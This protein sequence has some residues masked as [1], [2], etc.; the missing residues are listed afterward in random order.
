MEEKLPFIKEMICEFEKKNLIPSSVGFTGW[1]FTSNNVYVPSDIFV[2]GLSGNKND[3]LHDVCLIMSVIAENL[4]YIVDPISDYVDNFTIA[5]DDTRDNTDNQ[6]V[7]SWDTLKRSLSTNKVEQI[8][9][10]EDTVNWLSKVFLDSKHIDADSWCL[11]CRLIYDLFSFASP[12]QLTPIMENDERVKA[13]IERNE[14]HPKYIVD[15][16]TAPVIIDNIMEA[17]QEEYICELV[18]KIR[19]ESFIQSSINGASGVSLFGIMQT[20]LDRLQTKPASLGYVCLLLDFMCQ[21]Y[22]SKEKSLNDVIDY[23][24]NKNKN[25]ESLKEVAEIDW[26]TV[27][28]DV[29]LQYSVMERVNSKLTREVVDEICTVINSNIFGKLQQLCN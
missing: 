24:N 4:G 3:L 26:G 17:Y 20:I 14:Y 2:Y 10:L 18:F 27:F 21:F 9:S 28:E 6:E 29:G 16:F 22:Q 1:I 8:K 15:F 11:L 7:F 19:D 23:K 13:I 25:V 12:D 5:T